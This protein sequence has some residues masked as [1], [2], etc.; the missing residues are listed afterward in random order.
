VPDRNNNNRNR[1]NN[2]SRGS[3]SSGGTPHYSL[4]E[5]EYRG[6]DG[7][8]HHHTNTYMEQHGRDGGKDGGKNR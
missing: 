3:D 4:K 2:G 7:Q 8:I 5:R 1:D 6:P